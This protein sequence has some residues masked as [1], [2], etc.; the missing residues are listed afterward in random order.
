MEDRLAY[1]KKK[2][3]DRRIYY[4]SY[5]PR[6]SYLYD[7]EDA[8]DDLLWLISEVERLRE[9]SEGEGRAP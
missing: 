3:K 8:E 6:S 5:N 7:I 1:I 4:S 2:L 9:Q